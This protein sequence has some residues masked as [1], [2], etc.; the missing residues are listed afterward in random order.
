MW[1]KVDLRLNTQTAVAEINNGLGSYCFL[2][3]N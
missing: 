2:L 1:V 3:L